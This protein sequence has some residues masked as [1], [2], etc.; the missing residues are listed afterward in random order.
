[1][2]PTA[3]GSASGVGKVSRRYDRIAPIYRFLVGSMTV[4]TRLRRAAVARLQLRPGQ[5]VVEIGCGS[6]AHLPLLVEAVGP[7]GKVIGIDLSPGM[8]ERARR[9]V[10]EHG[11]DN[12]ILA[13]DDAHAPTSFDEADA[14][15]FGLSYA[16][17]PN[18]HT[19]LRQAWSRLSPGGTLVISEGFVPE[20]PRILR[21]VLRTLSSLTV[22]GRVD[23]KPWEDLA[24]LTS[25][26]GTERHRGGLYVITWARKPL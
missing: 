24:E 10:T 25:G 16:I 20:R 18:P 17:I 23:C 14:I 6:G 22:L 7:T 1:M 15:F 12:V 11:W 5:N 2:S 8:L 4:T 9:V 3:D 26:V 13:R 21:P 19:A